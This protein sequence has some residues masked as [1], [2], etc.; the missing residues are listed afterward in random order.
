ML[1][2]LIFGPPGAGKGTQSLK[3]SEKYNLKHISTGDILREEIRKNTALGRDAKSYMDKGHLVPDQLLIG[4]LKCVIDS[5]MHVDGFVFDGFPRTLIQAEAF[6][7]MMEESGQQIKMVL[8]L[9]VD[10]DEIVQRLVKR[11]AEQGR[12]DDTPEVVRNRQETYK[13]QTFPLLDYYEKQGKL[14]SL[15]GIGEIEDIFGNITKTIES[16]K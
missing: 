9:E 13:R 16:H 3:I 4:I 12:T 1:N 8:S 5:S 7:K 2:I 15:Q 6:D 14:V 11:A 10:Q